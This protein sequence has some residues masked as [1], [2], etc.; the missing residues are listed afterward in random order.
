MVPTPSGS[1]MPEKEGDPNRKA[2]FFSVYLRPW[3]LDRSVATVEVPHI[4]DLDVLSERRCP[5]QVTRRRLRGK[6]SPQNLSE[7][8][9]SFSES[10]RNYIRGN[11]VSRHSQKIIFQLMAANCGKTSRTENLEENVNG[12]DRGP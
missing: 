4:A 5:V 3:V 6:Q 2:R 11:V 1:P 7:A 9:R 8:Q 10:W 12:T